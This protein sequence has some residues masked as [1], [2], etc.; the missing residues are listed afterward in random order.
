MTRSI[1]G[2]LALMVALAMEGVAVWV[3]VAR[4]GGVAWLAAIAAHVCAAGLAAEGLSRLAGDDMYLPGWVLGVGLPMFGPIGVVAMVPV[5][6]AKVRRAGVSMEERRRRAAAA[7]EESR[8][9]EQQ[10]DARLDAIVDALEDRDPAVRVA[11]IDALRGDYSKK[12]VK[13]LAMSRTN[14]VYD[15]RMRAVEGLARISQHYNERIVSAKQALEAAPHSVDRRAELAEISLAYA[16][17]DLEDARTVDRLRAAAREHAEEAW[18][19]APEQRSLSALF[20]RAC[21][22]TGEFDAAEGLYR[23]LV[24]SDDLDVEALTGICECRFQMRDFE[25]LPL[26]SRWVRRQVGANVDD[27]TSAALDF[28]VRRW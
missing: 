25:M 13:I 28:W 22:Q 12:A 23:E 6:W 3:L 5:R 7:A 1:S 16:E 4:V 15:V 26:V 2:V 9:A 18:R 14:S 11:A 19:L 24:A 10:V 17:L 27:R 8:R 20:A 21:F